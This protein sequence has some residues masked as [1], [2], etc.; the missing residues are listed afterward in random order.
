MFKNHEDLMKFVRDA[1]IEMLDLKVIDLPGRWHHMTYSTRHISEKVFT[2]GTGISLSPY[3]GYRQITQGDMKVVPDPSTAFIDPFYEAKTLSVICDILLPD[4]QPYERDP[5]RIARAAEKYILDS[6]INARSLWLPELEFH[7]FDEVRYGSFINKS[8]YS[9]DCEWGFWNADNDK[10]PQ[11]GSK[12]GASGCG[13]ADAPR[14]RLFN[15]RTE[16][17]RRI[18]NAGY[19]V[20]YHHHELGGPGQMEIE[21][22]FEPLLRAADSVMVMKYMVANTARQAGKTVTFMPKPLFDTPGNGMH[23]HQYLEKDGKSLFY[24]NDGYAKLSGMA[25][26]YLGGLFRHTPALMAL[27]NPSTNSYRRFGVGMAAP[28]SLFFGESNRSSAI[29]IPSYSKNETDQRVEYRLPDGLCNPY[30]AIA[31]QLMAGLDGVLDKMDPTAEGYGPFDFNNYTLSDEE[32]AKIRTAP[33][34]LE[35]TLE[36]L[37]KDSA[38]LTRGGVFPEE[39]VSAWT[40]LKRDEL[41][42]VKSRPHPAEFDLYYDL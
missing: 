20:K 27:T 3:Q 16:M 2:D 13:Q 17:V 11:L 41:R 4:G 33:S 14:D 32:K 25:L 18:E 38:F 6:G 37:E 28:M 21:P 19:R 31:A 35:E 36:A 23:F 9:V 30:L 42:I 29:R 1:D 24:S 39:I 40:T 10:W 26:S 8:F 34:S 7:V 22:Y 12:L 5:R 15:L